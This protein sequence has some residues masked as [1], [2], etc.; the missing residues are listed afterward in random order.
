MHGAVV[1]IPNLVQLDP[2]EGDDVEGKGN[3]LIL[4]VS[5]IPAAS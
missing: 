2:L 4:N 1:V 5:F 3:L